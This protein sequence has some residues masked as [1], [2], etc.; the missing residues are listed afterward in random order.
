MARLPVRNR[1][2]ILLLM[3]LLCLLVLVTAGLA[4]FVRAAGPRARG[5]M[6]PPTAEETRCGERLRSDVVFLASTL[7][8]RNTIRYRELERTAASI[9]KRFRELGYEV[10]VQ[11]FEAPSESGPRRVRNIEAVLWGDPE[12]CI[13]VGAHYDSPPGSPGADDNASGVAILL[14][15]ARLQARSPGKR[16]LRF[17]AFVN[18]EPPYFR[19]MHMGSHV[20]AT[21]L[22]GVQ[23]VRVVGM[24]SLECLGVF[25][26]ERGS[27]T[28]PFPMGFFYPHRGDFV[29]FVSNFA[30]TGLMKRSVE[31][32]RAATDLPAE[33][34]RAPEVLPGIGWS[35][36]W[37][38]WQAG[39]P[40]IMVT[41]TALF[42]N[43]HYH[44]SGDTPEKLDYGRMAKAV[45]GLKGVLDSLLND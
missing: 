27:Q 35:D 5:P 10:R 14:E 29:S 32:F 21:D 18:E 31:A 26:D 45:T 12:E 36:H 39:F 24:L 8:E 40:A 23:G 43:R 37:A 19:T 15:L 33:G 42:R 3:S 34:A 13:V 25:S 7:G 1:V 17:V 22:K 4:F 28:F 9:G 2:V 20:Y 30:S 38:F 6:T 11:E 44:Q 16:T 41:D